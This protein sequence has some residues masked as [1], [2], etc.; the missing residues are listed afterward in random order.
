MCIRDRDKSQQKGS[1]SQGKQQSQQQSDQLAQNS[2]QQ[3]T[4]APD[5]DTSQP[6]NRSEPSGQLA[7]QP[8][9]SAGQPQRAHQ[10]SGPDQHEDK[11]AQVADSQHLPGEMS[12]EEARELL[13]SVKDEERRLP[14]MPVARTDTNDTSSNEAIKDW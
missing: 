5:H 2:S 6:Q 14:T 4:P 10:G 12:R 11:A 13:D 7:Q 9:P 8:S 3:K 1:Q